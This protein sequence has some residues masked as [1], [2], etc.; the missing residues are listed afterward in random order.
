MTLSESQV[1]ASAS[2]IYTCH[3]CMDV[4]LNICNVF[5]VRRFQFGY[6][7]NAS[8]SGSPEYLCLISLRFILN[9]VYSDIA[10]V[11]PEFKFLLFVM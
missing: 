3:V 2:D 5:N 6:M 7:S 4:N 9:V 10:L 1:L 11:A 8:R